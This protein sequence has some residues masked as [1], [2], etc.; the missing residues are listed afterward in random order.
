MS[1][2]SVSSSA[3]SNGELLVGADGTLCSSESR[4]DTVDF[5][6]YEGILG[7]NSLS[8]SDKLIFTKVDLRKKE[9]LDV[10]FPLHSGGTGTLFPP[11]SFRGL[12]RNIRVIF[13]KIREW[14]RLSKDQQQSIL[15]SFRSVAVPEKTIYRKNIVDLMIIY[16]MKHRS[17]SSQPTDNYGESF[18]E[19]LCIMSFILF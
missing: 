14:R 19:Y 10:H 11:V 15:T 8:C 18:V 17:S 7:F 4:E 16:D 12:S 5:S 2:L 1:D 13:A 9:S 6:E 3:T